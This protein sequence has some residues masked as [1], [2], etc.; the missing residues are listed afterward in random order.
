MSYVL[1]DGVVKPKFDRHRNAATNFSSMVTGVNAALDEALI[2]VNHVKKILSPG[3]NTN[4]LLTY[5]VVAS[6][7]AIESNIKT[8]KAEISTYANLLA[9]PAK[10]FDL[11]EERNWISEHCVEDEQPI[12]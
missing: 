1:P 2:E 9:E 10:N 12:N 3:K 8:V 4:D 11:E 7:E 5:N 6:N